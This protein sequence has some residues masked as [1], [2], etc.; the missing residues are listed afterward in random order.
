MTRLTIDT[1]ALCGF[2][3]RFNSFYRDSRHPF[4]EA[5]MVMLAESQARLRLPDAVAAARGAASTRAS[6]S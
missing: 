2:G 5:M 4:V 3:Y 1:I 6:S